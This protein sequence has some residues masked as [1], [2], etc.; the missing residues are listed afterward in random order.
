MTKT[1]HILCT[2]VGHR[3]F[4][5]EILPKAPWERTEFAT[6]PQNRHGAHKCLRCHA[7]LS[8]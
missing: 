5:P 4:R 7:E 2:I 6:V 3:E 8:Y 1:N